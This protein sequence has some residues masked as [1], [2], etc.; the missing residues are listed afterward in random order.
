MSKKR[1]KRVPMKASR[2]PVARKPV[3]PKFTV[4]LPLS[5][6]EVEM[7]VAENPARADDAVALL[8]RLQDNPLNEQTATDVITTLLVAAALAADVV[9]IPMQELTQTLENAFIAVHG[10]LDDFL[11]QDDDGARLVAPGQ[12]MVRGFGP[13]GG[14]VN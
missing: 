2:K 10:M 14:D 1:K 3:A 6:T 8:E 7:L 4:M 9:E 13:F 5:V 12:E 11:V